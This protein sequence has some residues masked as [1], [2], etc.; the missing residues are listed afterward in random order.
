MFFKM[1]RTN[2]KQKSHTIHQDN[3]HH[4]TKLKT[5]VEEIFSSRTHK[6]LEKYLYITPSSILLNFPFFELY[7]MVSNIANI[8][9]LV[10]LK[11]YTVST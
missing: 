4:T 9:L 3:S 10:S 2:V 11:R 6:C 7:V 5:Y 1:Y 8:M